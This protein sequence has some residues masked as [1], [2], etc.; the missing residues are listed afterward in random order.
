M[1]HPRLTIS[2]HELKE[3]CQRHGIVRLALFGSIL[4][5]NYST[6]SDIDMLVEFAPD[7][8][9]GYLTLAGMEL[10]LAQLLGREVDLRTAAELSHYFR[11][12]VIQAS[13]VQ[14]AA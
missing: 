3:Y 7:A 12:E 4:G 9:P 11:D 14:Y 8:A 2:E 10:E 6:D 5:E 1:L 13:Q